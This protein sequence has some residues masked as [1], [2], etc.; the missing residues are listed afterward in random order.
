MW[1]LR[2]FRLVLR[3][4][5]VSVPPPATIILQ[6]SIRMPLLSTIKTNKVKTTIPTILLLLLITIL[7]GQ[8]SLP[9]TLEKALQLGGANNL[10]IKEYQQRQ[11]LAA[12]QHTKA[13]EWWLPE[14]NAG[15]QTHQLLGAAMNGNG[16]FFIDISRNNLWAGLGLD[17]NWDFAEGIYAT[18]AAELKAKAATYQTQA[19]RNSAILNIINTY[20]DFLTAQL[21]YQAWQQLTIQADTLSQQI[22]IQVQAGLRY[23]S[24]VLLA[25]SNLNHLKVQALQAKGEYGR[26][27]ATL[28]ELLNLDPNIQLI[29]MDTIISPLTLISSVE[30]PEFSVAYQNRPEIK[31]QETI[32]K[33]LTTEKKTV[34]TGLLLPELSLNAFTAGFGGL[35]GAVEAI[36]PIQFPTTQQLYATNAINF[37][38]M[39]RIPLGNLTFAGDLKTYD[40][41]ILIQQTQIQQ[42]KATINKEIIAARVSLQVAKKQMDMA[43]EGS[44]LAGEALNQSIQRQN[45]GTV[46]PFEVLQAQEIFIK[47]RLDFIRAVGDYN[48]AQYQLYIF[49]G[50]NL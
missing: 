27:A 48:K 24:D 37:S 16:R 28:I 12:A 35:N 7:H 18:K 38:L 39:W 33:A 3:L 9:L 2:C 36:D 5:A 49:K 1:F 31:Q 22:D 23:Q 25:K 14:I 44:E 34:T 41:K 17:L 50:N 15:I 43:L 8:E 4:H 42:T 32:L 13:K 19:D 21:S 45:L 11:Q 10:T 29:A 30:K 20:Y 46:R 26:Q 40:A 6:E 47:A